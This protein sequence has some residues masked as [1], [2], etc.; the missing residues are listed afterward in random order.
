MGNELQSVDESIFGNEAGEEE[1]R[2]ILN[3]YFVRLEGFDRFWD[4]NTKLAIVKAR[5]GLGKSTLLSKLVYDKEEMEQDSIVIKIMG[6]EIMSV[7]EDDK[8]YSPDYLINKWQTSMC[9]RII[10]EIGKRIGFA[11]QDSTMSVVE[12]SELA[13]YKD[14]NII[15]SLLSR[16]KIKLPIA[17]KEKELSHPNPTELLKRFEMVKYYKAWIVIDDIDAT[18]I[19]NQYNSLKI[20][21]FLS[22][23]RK[24]VSDFEG[25]SIRVSIRSDV[26]SVINRLDEALD[27]CEQYISEL[28]WNQ[29]DFA[30]MLAS[31]IYYYFKRKKLFGLYGH[32]HLGTDPLKYAP[33]IISELFV[34]KLNWFDVKY[35]PTELIYLLTDGRPRWAINLCKRALREAK[36]LS[37]RIITADDINTVL[38]A[39]G[40]ARLE[41]LYKE[42]GQ[43]CPD[44]RK[45]IKLFYG[46]NAYYRV[47]DLLYMLDKNY[48]KTHPEIQFDGLLEKND[49]LKVA[50]YL[51]RIGFLYAN[52]LGRYNLKNIIRYDDNIGLLHDRFNLDWTMFWL[53]NPIFQKGLNLKILISEAALKDW[54]EKFF[55]P[56]Y[57]MKQKLL[58]NEKKLLEIGD[59]SFLLTLINI[60]SKDK[61][62]AI[63][64]AI[65][66]TG[67]EE[68][69]PKADIIKLGHRKARKTKGVIYYFELS[70]IQQEEEIIELRIYN[71]IDVEGRE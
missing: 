7:I 57:N 35:K 24:M 34:P 38:N 25:I 64:I 65:K 2:D 3:D 13:G 33:L 1:D 39:Y 31:K 41:D 5:K 11:L 19:N 32:I 27:K 20:S 70:E 62:P 58:K 48:V 53:V 17:L 54:V 30:K 15:G 14:K 49:C 67:K 22:S 21:T 61:K 45:I 46:K 8:E 23:C 42:Y 52:R 56:P 6:P 69:S 43:Q 51:F 10:Y 9:E 66:E 12:A 68:R 71:E 55:H 63:V 44:I 16:I 29:E 4:F 50:T 36:S 40:K 60:G 59:I 47:E 26:W 28:K 37:K 18:F